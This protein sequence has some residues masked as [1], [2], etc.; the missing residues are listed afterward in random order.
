[1][2]TDQFDVG[3]WEM[4]VHEL[5]FQA[6]ISVPVARIERFSS[7]FHTYLNRRFDRTETGQRIHFASAL[8]LLGYTDGTSYADGASYLEIAE[9][10][11]Q[12]GARVNENLKEL[13]KRIVFYICVSNTDDHLRNHGF[14]LTDEGWVL[15][16]A[17][18]INPA[19]SGSGLSLNISEDDNSLDLGLAREVAGYF[20][21]APKEADNL[22]ATITSVVGRWRPI[23]TG[24]GISKPEQ[25]R[26]ATAYK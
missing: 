11:I 21:I 6:G 10:I 26:M 22:I 13:W 9:F 2:K 12:N 16:P 8:T 25:E 17:Y 7:K 14:I 19:E 24:F 18:D 20:R 4:V 1:G 5:A 23:A 15:S 3:A